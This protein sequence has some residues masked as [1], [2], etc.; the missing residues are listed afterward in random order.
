[1]TS[2]DTTTAD[3]LAQSVQDLPPELYNMIFD[4]VF[5][6]DPTKVLI[7]TDYKPP[8]LLTVNR[9]S[10]QLFASRY[11]RSSEGF[12][13]T[14]EDLPLNWITKL[15]NAHVR[16]L[17]SIEIAC[18]RQNHVISGFCGLTGA[19][20]MGTVSMCMSLCATMCGGPRLGDGVLKWC[21]EC[22]SADRS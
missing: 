9:H 16:A 14:D 15:S 11:Y 7:T 18:S 22:E 19:I 2:T 5:T 3:A 13:F 4:L 20:T 21:C 6:P 10:R 8:H 17:G 12:R 1:M